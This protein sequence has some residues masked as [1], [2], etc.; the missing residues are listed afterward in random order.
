MT[1]M[2]QAKTEIL[3]VGKIFSSSTRQ[4]KPFFLITC[5]CYLHMKAVGKTRQVGCDASTETIKK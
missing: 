1:G 3:G 2:C 5:K 4:N